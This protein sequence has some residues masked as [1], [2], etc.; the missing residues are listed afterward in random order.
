MRAGLIGAIA[1]TLLGLTAP[2]SAY[3]ITILDPIPRADPFGPD[4]FTLVDLGT[5]GPNSFVSSA[6]GSAGGV[7]YSFAGG[8]SA[9]S[10][11][12][13]GSVSV[14]ASPYGNANTNRNYFSAGGGA[15]SVVL[16]YGGVQTALSMLWGTVDSSATRNLITTSA[17]ETINGSQILTACGAFCSNGN[18]NVW[19]SITGLTGYT[20]LTF[21][22]ATLN[23]FEF[24]VAA[25]P[26]PAT[27]GMMMLGFAGIGFMAYRRKSKPAL[28]LV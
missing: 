7:S 20:S 24:N 13:A 8:G 28:R 21:S 27:W 9:V 16:G 4:L 19:L 6:P 14:A 23:A 25:V 18:T 12:Y 3:T 15:G 1:L 22:D 17:G 26:E 10:G 2:A 11:I 5:G